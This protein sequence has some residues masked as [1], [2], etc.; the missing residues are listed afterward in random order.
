MIT[1]QIQAATGEAARK[2]MLD[3][4]RERIQIEWKTVDPSEVVADDEPEAVDAEETADEAPKAEP[5]KRGRKPKNATEQPAEPGVPS[6][7]PA[8]AKVETVAQAAETKAEGALDME[9]LRKRMFDLMQ[10]ENGDTS[11]IAAHLKKFG[12][13]KISELAAERYAEFA[14]GLDARLAE[15]AA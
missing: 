7:A 4:L 3:L 1:I 5:K 10:V 6:D 11:W 2:E 15:K 13:A 9:A 12:I 14:E 8:V